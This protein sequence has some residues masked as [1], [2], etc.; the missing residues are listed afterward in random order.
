MLLHKYASAGLSKGDNFNLVMAAFKVTYK[1]N[2]C[3]SKLKE[4]LFVLCFELIFLWNE[5]FTEKSRLMSWNYFRY[6]HSGPSLIFVQLR[7]L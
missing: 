7:V 2:V 6:L 1:S 3:I 5:N 4:V